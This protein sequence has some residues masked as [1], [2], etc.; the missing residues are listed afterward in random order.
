M[1]GVICGLSAISI[2]REVIYIGR[3]ARYIF[4]PKFIRALSKA[5]KTEQKFMRT[6]HACPAW[7][8]N[9]APSKTSSAADIK[10]IANAR[11]FIAIPSAKIPSAANLH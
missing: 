9:P 11:M 6:F 7:R 8:Q 3:I 10:R 2:N 1:N 5:G 4:P